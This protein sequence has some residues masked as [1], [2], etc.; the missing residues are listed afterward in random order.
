M[1][2]KKF[3]LC[4]IPISAFAMPNP[5][6]NQLPGGDWVKHCNASQATL[7]NGELQAFCNSGYGM[8]GTLAKLDYS[9]NCKPGANVTYKNGELMCA[10]S[11]SHN[12]NH[13]NSSKHTNSALPRGNWTKYCNVK[14]ATMNHGVL[15]AFCSS[16]NG[17][18]GGTLATLD[19]ATNCKR[20]AKVNYKAGELYC[21]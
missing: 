13:N 8:G 16:K 4:V 20:G 9:I 19:Y 11:N 10:A 18:M 5:N 14:Q 12:N 21:K 2:F 3:I 7:H 6:S 17:M 15:Q 1:N